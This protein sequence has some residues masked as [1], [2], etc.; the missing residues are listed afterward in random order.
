V[1]SRATHCAESIVVKEV[2]DT[3]RKQIWNDLIG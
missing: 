2:F 3:R 1:G